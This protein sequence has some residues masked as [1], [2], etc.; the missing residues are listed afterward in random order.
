MLD[1][2]ETIFTLK[3]LS[4][5]AESSKALTNYL[6]GV[7]G[8]SVDLVM[9]LKSA[10]NEE[11]HLLT[12]LLSKVQQEQ[13]YYVLSPVDKRDVLNDETLGLAFQERWF[14]FGTRLEDSRHKTRFTQSELD[15]LQSKLPGLNI[16]ESKVRVEEYDNE[17]A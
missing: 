11:R 15:S 2:Q 7:D 3:T 14:N 16:E 8:L 6:D 9:K 1:I 10:Q 13:L 17:H 12:T 5:S 4:E